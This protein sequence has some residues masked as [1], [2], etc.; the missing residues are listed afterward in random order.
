MSR[1]ED[2]QHGREFHVQIPS[3]TMAMYRQIGEASQ[4]DASMEKHLRSQPTRLSDPQS[5]REHL[6]TAHDWSEHDFVRDESDREKVPGLSPIDWEKA[7]REGQMP[8]L[9]HRDMHVLHQHDH[10]QYPEEPHTTLG[11]SHFHS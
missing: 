3:E 5:L 11:D 1:S 10:D 4:L 7:D 6:I 9:S 8:S 2:F